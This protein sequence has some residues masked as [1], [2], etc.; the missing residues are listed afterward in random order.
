MAKKLNLVSVIRSDQK[1][2]Q[3]DF[4]AMYNGGP[5]FFECKLYQNA[6]SIDEVFRKWKSKQIKQYETALNVDK[7]V[8]VYLVTQIDKTIHIERIK[9]VSTK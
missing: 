4:L 3:P 5:A 8:P 2:K 1:N 6:K 9:H 7:K